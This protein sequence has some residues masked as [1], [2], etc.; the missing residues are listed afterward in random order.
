MGDLE[1]FSTSLTQLSS[2]F[3][4]RRPKFVNISIF[5]L[6]LFKIVNLKATNN[7]KNLIVVR[8]LE[9]GFNRCN[10]IGMCCLYMSASGFF[11]GFSSCFHKGELCGKRLSNYMFAHGIEEWYLQQLMGSGIFFY[12]GCSYYQCYEHVPHHIYLFG[13][14]NSFN[15]ASNF[16]SALSI[17]NSSGCLY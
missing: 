6:S 14:R 16:S 2:S 13:H 8:N 5:S 12:Y 1:K 7:E 10:W 15:R 17:P 9:K 11:W 4:V 3:W